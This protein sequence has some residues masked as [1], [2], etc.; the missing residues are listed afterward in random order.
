MKF[1][2]FIK[3]CEGHG[4]IYKFD[5]ELWLTCGNVMML[6][7]EYSKGV[8]ADSVLPIPDYLIDV[9]NNMNRNECE[10]V[11]ARVRTPD[12]KSKDIIR[13]FEDGDGIR[14]SISNTDYGLL[15]KSDNTMLVFINDTA[16]ALGVYDHNYEMVGTFIDPAY[17]KKYYK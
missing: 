7:P 8:V 11:E 16:V 12:G 14:F 3:S 2:K 9:I 1:N 10:L 6:I 15:E 5:G 13:V 4:V 17:I